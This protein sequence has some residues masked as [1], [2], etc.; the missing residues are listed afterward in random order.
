MI[1]DIKNPINIRFRPLDL[2]RAQAWEHW[3]GV[4]T[5]ELLETRINYGK[6]IDEK[7]SFLKSLEKEKAF[8]IKCFSIFIILWALT[9]ILTGIMFLDYLFPGVGAEYF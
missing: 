3:K 8:L 2:T 4:V 6:Y 1:F 7:E 5:P 9:M